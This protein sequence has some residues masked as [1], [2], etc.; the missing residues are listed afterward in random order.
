M[1]SEAFV[2]RR[3]RRG[4]TQ[5]ALIGSD[6]VMVALASGVASLIRFGRLRHVEAIPGSG[7]NVQFADMSLVIMA[8]WILALSFEGLY[9]VDRVFWGTGEYSRVARGLSL[10]VVIF[11]VATF[12][13][14][15]PGLSRGW[16]MLTWGFGI[17]FV[18]IGRS[19]VRYVLARLRRSGRFL[20]RTLVVG[21]NQ[22]AADLLRRLQANPSS[23]L[24]PVACLASSRQDTLDLQY[25]TPE[26][27]CL[28]A[29]ADIVE[30]LAARSFD[31]VLIASTA[32]DSEVLSRIIADLRGADVDIELSSGLLDVTTSRVLIREVSGVPLVLVRGVSF[33][34]RKRLV[35]RAFDLTVGAAILLVGT[36]IWLL[37]ALLIKLD[38][39]GPILYKQVRLG[40][41]G[42]PFGMYKFRS[43]RRDADELLQELSTENE[44]SGPLFKMRDDPRIT[45]VGRWLRRLSID[46]IPQL[47]NVMRGQMSLVGP[48]PPLPQEASAY[49]GYHWRRM[50]VLPGMTGLWQVS[51][52]SALTFDEMVRL[53]LFY[54]ENWSVGF[55]LSIMLRTIPAVLS[56]T[57]AY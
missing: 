45:R 52:R 53:D 21:Y 2:T 28:G 14:K 31:T 36:P 32:F 3:M 44:A 13:L 48:R 57:G 42:N 41:D 24:T 26:I 43:M 19:L 23:G 34:L 37:I 7:I 20:R 9:D 39:R 17:I 33:S 55:D 6:I 22:E 51:G 1:S 11:I 46:E 30:V 27:E 16:V 25:C 40:R 50:E 38:S 56:T 35:K 54:I 12:A 49:S 5:L 8:V 29:A 10:G 18:V 4:Y 47:L 15:L